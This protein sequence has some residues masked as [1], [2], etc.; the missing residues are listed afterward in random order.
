M[1]LEDVI[2]KKMHELLK[3]SDIQVIKE[4]SW[5]IEA[6]TKEW[7]HGI[8]RSLDQNSLY[9]LY[10]SFLEKEIGQDK[11]DLHKE[12]RKMFLGYK[13][14][15]I[16]GFISRDLISTKTL[17]TSEFKQYIDKILIYSAME[18]GV[19]MPDTDDPNFNEFALKYKHLI[20]RKVK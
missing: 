13:V 10:L 7:Y 1:K 17:N 11:E 16:Q 9:W 3:P 4:Y 8:I 5:F 19:Y 6:V 15:T 2:K 12:F 18:L 20:K 14:N